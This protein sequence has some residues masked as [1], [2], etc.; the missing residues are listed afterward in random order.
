MSTLVVIN[1][2][3]PFPAPDV[4][5]L[6]QGRTIAVMPK[7]FINPGRQ[8]ALYPCE[9]SI[10][11][12]PTEQYYRSNF[13]P[14]AQSTLAELDSETVLIKAW[15]RCEFCQVL[16][17]AQYLD[18]LSQLTVWT[19]EALRQTLSQRG[20]IFL[21]YLRVYRLPQPF[22]LPV[23]FNSRFITLP[24]PLTVTD[25]T[26]VFGNLFFAQRCREMQDLQSSPYPELEELQSEIA[27]LSD[28]NLA[29]K[30]ID[31]EI[32]NFLGGVTPHPVTR[33]DSDLIWIDKIAEASNTSKGNEFALLVQKSLLK[34]GFT[35]AKSL[36]PEATGDTEGMEVYF[37]HPYRAIAKC[38]AANSEIIRSQT[39]E[40]FIEL[41]KNSLKQNYN[42]CIKLIVAAGEVTTDA[43][44]R[45]RKNHMSVIRP[46]TLQ[47]LVELQAYYKGSIDLMKLKNCLAHAYGWADD[48]VERYLD[49]VRQTIELRSRL[50]QLVK[51]YLHNAGLKD[52]ATDALHHVYLASE[53][54]QL[55]TLDAMHD[56]LIELSSPLTGYLG[57]IKGKD[58]R[59]DRFYFLRDLPF[60]N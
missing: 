17:E 54:P 4:E 11:A 10:N 33:L 29:A 12:L 23:Q 18:V 40:Q 7:I 6:I 50:V 59:S 58:L 22:E 44:L 48:S 30:E 15:A 35:N 19:K 9:T 28:R 34:L 2:A 14:T 8:F 24:E 21:T 1:T 36:T 49:E 25:T 52:A 46:E 57:R 5:A 51:N 38:Q 39:V 13:L 41:A 27:P 20:H 60:L 45:A 3:F 32:A 43:L 53:P 56:I 42:R 16:D 47:S 31:R 55:L 37:E 26:P